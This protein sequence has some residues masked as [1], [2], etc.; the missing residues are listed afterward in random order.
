[1]RKRIFNFQYFIIFTIILNLLVS[2]SIAD[3]NL[4]SNS[5]FEAID[6]F[7]PKYWR[8]NSIAINSGITRTLYRSPST[9]VYLSQ[10]NIENFIQQW[11]TV[12]DT[13]SGLISIDSTQYYQFGARMKYTAIT[14]GN[15]GVRVIW[16]DYSNSTIAISSIATNGTQTTLWMKLDSGPVKPPSGTVAAQIS[17][18]NSDSVSRNSMVWFDD[19]FFRPTVPEPAPFKL[20]VMLY[21]ILGSAQTTLRDLERIANIIKAENPDIVGLNEVFRTP[22]GN[23]DQI[24]A[25]F[26]GSQWTT[27]FGLNVSSTFFGLTYDYGNAIL[28]RYPIIDA[29]NRW[30]PPQ[31]GNEQRGC[32]QAKIN[33]NG[34]ILNAFVTHWAHNNE[35]ER[36]YSADSIL[37]WMNQVAEPKI[38]LGDLNARTY[39]VP[40]RKMQ[41]QYMDAIGITAFGTTYTFI[42][43]PAI[44]G[45]IDHIFLPQNTTILESH[46]VSYGDALVASDHFPVVVTYSGGGTLE[47]DDRPT[48][49]PLF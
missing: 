10:F 36:R 29:I 45:R 38:L 14:T 30:I 32:L 42:P 9:S 47:P 16:Y 39:S 41:S 19:V 6:N 28:S 13:F 44:V 1:M 31:P 2:G 40:L 22:L 20:R 26:L 21:N 43:N 46:I 33:I 27:V 34:T 24:I 18:F 11:F 37:I 48:S 5:D 15:S 7:Q 17:L 35:T 49:A 4:I 3:S 8:T 25:G 23:Q 12:A